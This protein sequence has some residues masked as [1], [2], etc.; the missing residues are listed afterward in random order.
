MIPPPNV[1]IGD[2]DLM[3]EL[4]QILASG[5]THL[6]TRDALSQI[7]QRCIL[8]DITSETLTEWA[9][10]AEMRDEI[11]Y[12]IG[13]E[14]HIADVMF[15]LSTPEINGDLSVAKLQALLERLRA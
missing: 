12:E 8:G 5:K 2:S 11:D 14:A 10:G 7:I 6:L 3:A 1:L 4:R 9:N 15:E 13:V